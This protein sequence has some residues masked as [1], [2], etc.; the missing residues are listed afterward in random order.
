MIPDGWLNVAEL[1]AVLQ[2]RRAGR[3]L[4]VLVDDL[5]REL[6]NSEGVSLSFLSRVLRGEVLP[7]EALPMALGYR[8]LGTMYEPLRRKGD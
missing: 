4:R 8:K 1:L 3:S 5:N 7:G 2:E 6:P